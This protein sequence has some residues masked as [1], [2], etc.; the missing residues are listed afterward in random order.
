VLPHAH[1]ECAFHGKT[2]DVCGRSS[3]RSHFS[4]PRNWT[5]SYFALPR[6]LVGSSMERHLCWSHCG[7]RTRLQMFP[8]SSLVIL[9]GWGLIDLP[10]RA[11][12]EGLLR[13]RV[14][15]AQKIIRLHPLPVLRARRAPGRFCSIPPSCSRLSLQGW[16]GRSSNARVERAHSDRA[17]SG[18]M[19]TTR[20]PFPSHCWI[21]ESRHF[22]SWI[23]MKVQAS[24]DSV[25]ISSLPSMR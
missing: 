18:S 3:V 25:G 2:Y 15:R 17:C 14:A 20:L 9:Q 4:R 16:A 19:R 5:G 10:L 24:P 6:L 7:R 22:P 12:N 1:N 23:R 8:P 11:S 21:A 13:P